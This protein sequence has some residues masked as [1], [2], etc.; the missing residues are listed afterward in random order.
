MQTPQYDPSCVTKEVIASN[1]AGAR[2]D[3]GGQIEG[4]E[5]A[6]LR[7]PTLVVYY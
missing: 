5:Q 1:Y 4:P 2:R 6:S 3:P 7:P